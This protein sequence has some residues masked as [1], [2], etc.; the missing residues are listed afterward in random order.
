MKSAKDV[1]NDLAKAPLLEGALDIIKLFPI[2]NPSD[3]APFYPWF[4]IALVKITL[5]N[6]NDT[7]IKKILTLLE[8]KGYD[9]N[10]IVRYIKNEPNTTSKIA[11]RRTN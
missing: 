7:D 10:H 4:V 8:L 2:H 3:K 5:D 1:L 11:P 9:S 6:F